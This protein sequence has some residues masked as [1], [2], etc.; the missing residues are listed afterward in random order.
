MFGIWQDVRLAARRLQQAPGFAVVAT[1]ILALGIGFNTA[2]FS[3]VDGVLIRGLPYSDADRLAAI[4]MKHLANPT[5]TISFKTFADWR[6]RSRTLEHAAAYNHLWAPAISDDRGRAQLLAGRQV[7]RDF[8]RVLG[9][10]VHLGRGFRYNDDHEGAPDVA[11]ISHGLWQTRF[12]GTPE[13]VGRTI[14]L[15]DRAYVVIG[16]LPESF[17]PVGFTSLARPV[18]IWAPLRYEGSSDGECRD[19]NHLQAIARIKRGISPEQAG[20]ELDQIQRSLNRE[21]PGSYTEDDEAHL[22]PFHERLVGNARPVL[23][24]LIGAV[25]LVLLICC[26][27]LANLFL[28]RGAERRRDLTLRFALGAGRARI[29]RQLFTENLLFATLGGAMGLLLSLWLTP[30]LLAMAPSDVSRLADVKVDWRILAFNLLVTLLTCLAFGALPALS[31]SRIRIHGAL[32]LGGQG[33]RNV[34]SNGPRSV[35]GAGEVALAVVLA[36]S[37]GLLLRS[38]VTLLGVDPGLDPRNVLTVSLILAGE[39]YKERT[40]RDNFYAQ[41]VEQV[42]AL[43]GVSAAAWVTNLPLGGGFDRRG[44]CIQE[45]PGCPGPNDPNA[46]SYVVTPDYFRVMGIPLLRGRVFT[47]ND[48]SDYE[49]VALVGETLASQ[50]W[51]GQNAIGKKIRLSGLGDGWRTIVGVVGDVRHFGLDTEPTI[52]AYVPRAQT[53]V[54]WGFLVVRT[55]GPPS[56]A[57]GAIRAAIAQVDPGVPISDLK[58]MEQHIAASV[59]QRRFALLLILLFGAVALVLTALGLYGVLAYSVSQRTQ[60]IGVRVALGAT[61]EDILRLVLTQASKMTAIGVACGIAVAL[62]VARILSSQLFEIGPT[63]PLTFGV[64][65]LLLL[66][67]AA[68]ASYVPVQR[69]LRINPLTALRHE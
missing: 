56:A 63:D 9:V 37:A 39:E 24:S 57:A 36:T 18:E 51:P 49:P 5:T 59:S 25:A 35:L 61:R 55:S 58:T 6:E 15:S 11:I 16:V 29:V 52:Q 65:L 19:C 21:F 10:Q 12:G 7:T 3:V 32:K 69:A 14:H 48:R 54:S 23:Y 53:R 34:T 40:A 66:A 8:F 44:L 68:A 47:E 30:A 67:V 26:A 33:S 42:R 64:V 13:I 38:F 43:P 4:A 22:T 20:K 1:G 41:L 28:I 27:N 31:A 45:R 17:R 2:M 50:Q 62:G 60:E 46:D